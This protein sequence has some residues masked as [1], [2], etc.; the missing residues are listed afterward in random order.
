MRPQANNHHPKWPGADGFNRAGQVRRD[1]GPGRSRRRGRHP[2]NQE[3]SFS[4]TEGMNFPSNRMGERMRSRRSRG[5]GPGARLSD[6]QRAEVRG[7]MQEARADGTVTDE[8]RAAIGDLFQ[9]YRAQGSEGPGK[10]GGRGPLSQLNEEQRTQIQDLIA[11]AKSDGQMT[12]EERQNIRSTIESL[13]GHPLQ[14]PGQN[15]FQNVG[16]QSPTQQYQG[17]LGNLQSLI[18]GFFGGY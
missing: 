7:L 5:Q 13:V 15:Q 16:F 12:P 17:G 3:A 6:E 18:Q 4:G 8:E 9:S 14:H 2:R 11:T 10:F 1:Q